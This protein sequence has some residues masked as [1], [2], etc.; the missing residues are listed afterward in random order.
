MYQGFQ[1][2]CHNINN[3]SQLGILSG[4]SLHTN[5]KGSHSLELSVYP[6]HHPAFYI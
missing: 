5:Y 2:D 3:L 1:Q 6:Y 4:D